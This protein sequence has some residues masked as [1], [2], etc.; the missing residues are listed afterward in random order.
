MSNRVRRKLKRL[1][2]NI[3]VP[4]EL[5]SKMIKNRMKEEVRNGVMDIGEPV[6]ARM[7]TKKKINSRGQ[8]KEIKTYI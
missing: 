7:C 2:Y 1:K 3:S 5:S 4:V 6:V 8:I